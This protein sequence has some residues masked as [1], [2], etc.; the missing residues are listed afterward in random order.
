MELEEPEQSSIPWL[1]RGTGE[2]AAVCLGRLP[3]GAVFGGVA[4]AGTLGG[5]RALEGMGQPFLFPWTSSVK[6]PSPTGLVRCVCSLGVR[7]SAKRFFTE[8]ETAACCHPGCE[9]DANL[10]VHSKI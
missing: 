7:Q 5:W 4:R 3:E 8:Q 2:R 6:P 10:H 1:E 9:L